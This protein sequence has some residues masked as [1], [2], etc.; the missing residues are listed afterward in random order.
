MARFGNFTDGATLSPD[1][2][3]RRSL[4]ASLKTKRCIDLTVFAPLAGALASA[5]AGTLDA[6]AKTSNTRFHGGPSRG[7]RARARARFV[8]F[9]PTT[10]SH[11]SRLGSSLL[12]ECAK[13]DVIDL[14]APCRPRD[15]NSWPALALLAFTF[16]GEGAI[17]EFPRGG[18]GTR[19][20][21]ETFQ[22]SCGCR[23]D[24]HDTMTDPKTCLSALPPPPTPPPRLLAALRQLSRGLTSGRSSCRLMSKSI[25]AINRALIIPR[26]ESA[27][28]A[29]AERARYEIAN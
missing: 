6:P 13:S 28:R 12:S 4:L 2:S 27:A 3:S 9:P 11:S 16:E 10:I 29:K 20:P 14:G 1:V 25:G 19:D 26:R 17:S 5:P 18:E 24:A 15:C 7:A 21:P 23:N 22:R 8:F